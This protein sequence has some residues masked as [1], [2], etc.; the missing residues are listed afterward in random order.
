MGCKNLKSPFVTIKISKYFFPGAYAEADRYMAL[1]NTP[2]WWNSYKYDNFSVQDYYQLLMSMEFSPI[3]GDMDG[4]LQELAARNFYATC[5]NYCNPNGALDLLKYIANQGLNTPGA[6]RNA[7]PAMRKSKQNGTDFISAITDPG[8]WKTGCGDGSVVC[9]WGNGSMVEYNVNNHK[10]DVG[11]RKR[12]DTMRNN[13]DPK[14]PYS[15][16]KTTF[17]MAFDLGGSDP[18]I[19]LTASQSSYLWTKP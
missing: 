15:S 16:S 2:G 18:W 7:T 5:G 10:T 19:A 1:A 9:F 13:Y 17:Y 4:H 8:E 3:K 6:G 11:A 12:Y 14:N